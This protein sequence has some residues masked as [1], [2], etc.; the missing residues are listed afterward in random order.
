[1][2][3]QVVWGFIQDQLLGMRWLDGLLGRGLSA[4]GL[5]TGSGLGASVQ[6]SCTTR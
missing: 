1:M 2:H 3:V 5:D 6:F 4:L